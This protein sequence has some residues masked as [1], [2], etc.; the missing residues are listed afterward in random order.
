MTEEEILGQ[1][2]AR[3]EKHRTGDA[4]FQL[5]GP[6]GQPL[7]AGTAVTVRQ[8]RHKFLFGA[9]IYKFDDCRTLEQNA[10]YKQRF[11]ELLNFATVRFYWVSYEIREGK[12][13]YADRLKIARWCLENGITPKGHPLFWSECQPEWLH[14]KDPGE[15]ESLAWSRI[16]REITAFRDVIQLAV[17][18]RVRLGFIGCGRRGRQLIPVFR[19]FDDV[20]IPVICDV[21]GKSM[22]EA[23]ELLARRADRERDYRK[24]LDRRDI[25]AVVIA[26]TEHWHGLPFIHACQAGK[27][28]FV[29]KPLSHTVVEGR[30]MVQAAKKAGIIAMMGTQQRG[31]QHYPSAVEI[32][33][34]GR[35]GK[36]SL[37]ECWNCMNIGPR[38]KGPVIQGE[39]PASLDWD[40]WL[41][42]APLVP[43]DSRRLVANFLWFD[44]GGGMMTNWAVHHVDT[45]FWAMQVDSPGRVSCLGGRFV[46][47]DLGDTPDTLQ[48]SWEF[49]GFLLQ[50]WY[51]GQSKFPG[52]LPR[53]FDHGIA[54][55]GD[56]ATLLLDRFGY[57][58]YDEKNLKQPAEKV[59]P[60]PQDGPWHRTFVDCVKEG[61]QPPVALEQSHQATVCCHLG[62]IAYRTRRTIRWDGQT[63]RIQGDDEAAAML[64][65]PRRA[66][67]E[68]PSV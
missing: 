62:N 7:P 58:V 34:S 50:Y 39:P 21:N 40:R 1:A 4:V 54:F 55:H 5:L 22:D 25:D 53:P 42:P 26:T 17:N 35:L 59:G 13:E 24:I 47:E 67:Y 63:E 49:P 33:R 19:Q 8:T 18:E 28:V 31:Q 66:G 65:R 57:E 38:F 51:R 43:F 44:Y 9:N 32:I 45:I 20:D 12:L 68:L 10:A 64:S 15:A 56:Q 3:I 23:Y 37:V 6:D 36:I 41:G 52:Q 11:R 29:E 14:P 30:A 60:T 61:R 46:V 27:H 48:A 2:D 16:G